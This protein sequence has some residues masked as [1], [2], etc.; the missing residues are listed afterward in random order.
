[1]DAEAVYHGT[2]LAQQSNQV[3][4]PD[5]SRPHERRESFGIP[6]LD[7]CH[8]IAYQKALEPHP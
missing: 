2:L 6:I 5:H 7:L 8:S 1:V 4:I 3:Q